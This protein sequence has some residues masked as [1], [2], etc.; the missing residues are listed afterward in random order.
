MNCRNKQQTKKNNHILILIAHLSKFHKKTA[1]AFAKDNSLRISKHAHRLFF[2]KATG[3][4]RFFLR[5]RQRCL[6]QKPYGYH[7]FLRQSIRAS[8]EASSQPAAAERRAY[9]F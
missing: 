9:G 7:I 6:F 4:L 3:N 8:F 2:R 5:Y 1:C